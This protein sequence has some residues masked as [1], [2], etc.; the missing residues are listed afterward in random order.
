LKVG[1]GGHIG[2]LSAIQALLTALALAAQFVESSIDV[3][4]ENAPP[5]K[6]R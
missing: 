5:K 3:T 1:D 4:I 2:G 6:G